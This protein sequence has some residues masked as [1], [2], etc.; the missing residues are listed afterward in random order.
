MTETSP[1]DPVSRGT[2]FPAPF[3][4]LASYYPQW[5]PVTEK[6]RAFMRVSTDIEVLRNFHSAV[7]PR[8][9][10]MIVYFNDFPNDP[11]A[12]PADA[13][14]LYRLAQMVMEASA[15]IDLQWDS[16]DIE[17][18][19]PMSRMTFIAADNQITR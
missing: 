5:C 19:F 1:V 7:A 16:A 13:Q 14:R 4:D 2:V 6:E 15:P 8:M 9:E 3:A 11:A 17:D 10:E 18:V 12:L